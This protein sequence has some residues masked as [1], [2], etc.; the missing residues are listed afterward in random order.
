MKNST[1]SLKSPLNARSTVRL[2]LER[3]EEAIRNHELKPGDKLAPEAELAKDLGVG[4]SSIRE[5]FRML[6]ALGVI[7]TRRGE[8]SYV[9][10][11][12][13]ADYLN[14]IVI[15][16][17]REQGTCPDIFELRL[18]IEP[19]IIALATQRASQHDLENLE[20]I[21]KR[22]ESQCREDVE[23]M[24]NNCEFHDAILCMTKNPFLIRIGSIVM[25]LFE[26]SVQRSLPEHPK[27]KLA[28]HKRILE[29]MKT[30]DP[31]IVKRVIAQNYS[32]WKEVLPTALLERRTES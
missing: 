1:P 4:K 16:L 32:R 2:V 12:P 27:V 19:V 11:Y 20:A 23:F 13:S 31:E 18:L 24:E 28:M 6:E 7:V 3:L 15:A 14:P 8:G 25:Q 22:S 21:I 10:D 17:L 30:K 29:A 9:A 5:A 26:A